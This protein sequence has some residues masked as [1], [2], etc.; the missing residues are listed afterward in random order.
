MNTLDALDA[1]R[2]Q[3]RVGPAA[4]D[5][6]LVVLGQGLADDRSPE[7]AAAARDQ[8]PRHSA[9]PRRRHRLAETVAEGSLVGARRA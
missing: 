8:D 1:D 2:L 3:V 7:E 4:Q 5:P 9:P 6:H